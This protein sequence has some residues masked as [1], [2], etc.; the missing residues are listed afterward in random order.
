MYLN[1]NSQEPLNNWRL[2]HVNTPEPELSVNDLLHSTTY[3]AKINVINK[4]NTVLEA[5]SLYRFT[6]IGSKI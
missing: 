5:P 4:D 1:R 3:F 2:I 6:T